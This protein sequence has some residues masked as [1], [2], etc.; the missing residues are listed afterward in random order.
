ML[1]CLK[2]GREIL[3]LL[4]GEGN[5]TC[6]REASDISISQHL[7]KNHKFFLCCLT[8]VSHSPLLSLKS[9]STNFH[10]AVIAALQSRFVNQD[11]PLMVVHTLCRTMNPFLSPVTQPV[12]V[13][14]FHRVCKEMKTSHLQRVNCGIFKFPCG[15]IILIPSSNSI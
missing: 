2:S 7:L 5:Y 14:F 15:I 11:D 4:Q 9:C 6:T 8:A 1:L 12:L 10:R 13:D 3:M